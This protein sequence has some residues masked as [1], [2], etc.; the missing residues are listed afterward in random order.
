MGEE[1]KILVM[2]LEIKIKSRNLT[3][4][5]GVIW[6]RK[7]EVNLFTIFILAAYFRICFWGIV[8]EK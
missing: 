3:K 5:K 7:N 8:N 2:L 1:G 6:L 4:K